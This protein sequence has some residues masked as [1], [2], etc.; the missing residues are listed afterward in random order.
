M[1]HTDDEAADLAMPADAALPVEHPGG[2]IAEELAARGLSATRAAILMHVPQS[3]LSRI[4]AGE[5]GI[6]ADT[7]LRLHRLLGPSPMFFLNLQSQYDLAVATRDH[8][9]RIEA[10]CRQ[11]GDPHRGAVGSRLHHG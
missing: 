3:R 6:T 9:A 7:A 10:E 8:G 2:T 4:L 5:R 11:Y 1:T